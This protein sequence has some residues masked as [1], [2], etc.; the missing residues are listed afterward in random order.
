[1]VSMIGLSKENRTKSNGI[2]AD[3]TKYIGIDGYFSKLCM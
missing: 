3:F 1:M 2:Y